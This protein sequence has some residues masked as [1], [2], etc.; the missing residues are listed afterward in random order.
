AFDLKGRLYVT[1]ISANP[2]VHGVWRFTSDGHGARIT[3]LPPGSAPNG[4]A[5]DEAHG[6]M[7]IADSFGGVIWRAAM[8][9]GAGEAW[10][11]DPLLAPRPL[12]GRF[13]GAN[14]LQRA[15]TAVLVT[16]SDRGLLLRVPITSTGAAGPV[17]VVAAGLPGDDFAVA[18][19][20]G[21]YVTTHPF[22]TVIHVS[23]DGR[24]RV[25][26]GPE[27]E[28]VGPTS[29]ALTPD[30]KFLYV[31]TD[32][33]LYRPL[34]GRPPVARVV[35]L[36]L[37][38]GSSAT[39]AA[40]RTPGASLTSGAVQTSGAHLLPGPAGSPGIRGPAADAHAR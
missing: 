1:V 11:R 10:I 27:Q 38:P 17:E 16:V 14:G 35:K 23:R 19:D 22:N 13:P 9:G 8:S 18:P 21:V 3:T 26:A 34:P 37:T 7:L 28:V 12:V 25:I 30:G 33:G 2:A 24:R 36:Q 4:L 40:I 6:L 15:G 20:G 39:S 32:G 31:A 29:A 5:L